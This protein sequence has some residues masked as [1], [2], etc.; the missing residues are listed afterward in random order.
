MN[1]IRKKNK[2]LRDISQRW[3]MRNKII[4]KWER[5]TDDERGITTLYRE[6]QNTTIDKWEKDKQTKRKTE[7]N[8]V[9]SRTKKNER[10]GT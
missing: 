6:L 9:W 10:L 2:Q 3:K 7:R 5:E 1:N 4:D 8:Y